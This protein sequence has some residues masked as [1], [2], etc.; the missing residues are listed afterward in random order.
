[1]AQDKSVTKDPGSGSGSAGPTEAPGVPVSPESASC[2]GE[3]GRTDDMQSRKLAYQNRRDKKREEGR[4]NFGKHL[5]GYTRL[6]AF[7]PSVGLFIAAVALTIST[8]VST[9]RV[10]IEVAQA[11]VGMQD[12]LVEYIEYADFFLLS[13]VLYIMS[14][15][16]YSLFIDDEIELPSWLAIHT[17][18]DLKEKLVSVIVVVMGVFFL[19]R[20]IH[21]A[22]AS[23]LL[24]MG[25][26]IGAVTLALAYFVRHVMVAHKGATHASPDEPAEEDE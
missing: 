14:I 3:G 10:T 1:M 20:L 11:N 9:V 18:D 23:D 12:M 8:L 5:L 17:L 2:R 25:I 19:G 26:G 22:T 16:L 7:I 13:I 6:M 15:G 4:R 21:G 24:C